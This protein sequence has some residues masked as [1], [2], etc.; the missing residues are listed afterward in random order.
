MKSS[1]SSRYFVTGTN[2]DI[3]KTFV[4]AGLANLS[5][6]LGRTTAVMKPI[7]TGTDDYDSDLSVIRGMVPG[8][9]QYDKELLSPYEFSMAA[10]PHLAAKMVGATIDPG[11]LLGAYDKINEMDPNTILVEG[12]GGIYVPVYDDYTMLDLMKELALPVILVGTVELGAI[13]HALLSI[14]ALRSAGLKIAG[15]VLNKVPLNPSAIELDNIE[16]I[17]TLGKVSLLGAIN[18]IESQVDIESQLFSQ[19][20]TVSFKQLFQ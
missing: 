18:Q 6:S 11:K 16:T 12:A 15:I 17:K 13:N 8:I 4:T 2:T 9:E 7:Q 3:G 5:V 10:S 20:N 19:F 1:M 14:E